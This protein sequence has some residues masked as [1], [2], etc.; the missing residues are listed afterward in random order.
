MSYVEI[1]DLGYD[2]IVKDILSIHNKEVKAGLLDNKNNRATIGFW[3]EY[4]TVNTP[5]RSF[6]R[7]TLERNQDKYVSFF[8]QRIRFI[9]D[10]SVSVD[11]VFDDTGKLLKKDIQ[12]T[13]I[14]WESPKN[15]D[16]TVKI[17]GF[18]DPL[19]HHKVM[20]GLINYKIK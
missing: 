11:K 1:K 7:T 15:K 5:S 18:N 12:K 16:S 4:G 19:I 20:L 14:D 2:G 3:Q 8:A 13:I 10:K 9:I 17:K 6:L